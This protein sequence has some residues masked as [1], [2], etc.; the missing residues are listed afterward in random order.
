MILSKVTP[1]FKFPESWC[2]FSAALPFFHIDSCSCLSVGSWLGEGSH[3]HES[4]PKT[5]EESAGTRTGEKK[6]ED[7]A[8]KERERKQE[9][10]GRARTDFDLP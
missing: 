3:G 4:L 1:F 7:S 2:V 8:G 5:A 10:S 6:I 9:I